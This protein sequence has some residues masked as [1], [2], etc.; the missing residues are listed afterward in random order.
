MWST[1]AGCQ[2]TIH[3]TPQTVLR[4]YDND[5]IL[6]IIE[7]TRASVPTALLAVILT[8]VAAIV[9]SH[10][11]ARAQILIIRLDGLCIIKTKYVIFM[12]ALKKA[13]C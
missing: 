13:R 7:K 3:N 11:A 4:R 12:L 6:L 1:L 2:R 5:L 9:Y 10:E 8:K